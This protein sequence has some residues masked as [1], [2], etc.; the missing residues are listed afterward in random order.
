MGGRPVAVLL[1]HDHPDHGAFAAGLSG[2]YG[3]PVYAQPDSLAQFHN[4]RPVHDGE[5]LEFGDKR[6]TRLKC[7]HT[8]GHHPGTSTT[9]RA[10]AR[11]CAAT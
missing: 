8:P 7:L 2:R 1:T 10:R 5:C 11:W 3:I 6:S 9:M 4:G